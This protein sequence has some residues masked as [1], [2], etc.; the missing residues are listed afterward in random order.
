MKQTKMDCMKIEKADEEKAER[1]REGRLV[2]KASAAKS[3][4]EAKAGG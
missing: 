3:K 2:A 1:L 4:A